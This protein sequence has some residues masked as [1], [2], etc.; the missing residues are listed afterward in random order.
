MDEKFLK[1]KKK[2]ASKKRGLWFGKKS[3][4]S[5]NP[6]VIPHLMRDPVTVDS[7][8]HGND[9]GG[10]FLNL[11]EKFFNILIW[12]YRLVC[13][14]A[15]WVD[16][17]KEKVR[18]FT[19]G[20][21]VATRVPLVM[22]KW[23][24]G[25]KQWVITRV[26]LVMKSRNVRI[27]ALSILGLLLAYG[28]VIHPLTVLL[29]INVVLL[30]T[31]NILLFISYKKDKCVPYLSP[32]LR[33]KYLAA[34]ETKSKLEKLYSERHQLK[35][36]F[37]EVGENAIYLR[38]WPYLKLVMIT[39]RLAVYKVYLKIIYHLALISS[40]SQESFNLPYASLRAQGGRGNLG[41]ASPAAR[42]DYILYHQKQKRISAFSLSGLVVMIIATSFS[43]MILSFVF[44]NIFKT[45]AATHTMLQT[46]WA[47]GA[48]TTATSTNTSDQT[49]WT[50]YNAA[51]ST[52]YFGTAGE[53]SLASSTSYVTSTDDS[54]TI[55]GF[56]LSGVA[57]SST[58]ITGTGDSASLVVSSTSA[59]TIYTTSTP[60]SSNWIVPDGVTSVKV[61]AWG[62]GGG[63]GGTNSAPSYQGGGGGGGAYARVDALVVTAGNSIPYT[64]GAKGT[65]GNQTTGG[66]GGS[67]SFNTN[68][69]I[70]Y[71]GGGGGNSLTGTGGA[72]GTIAGS[73][74]DVKF[75]GGGGHAGGACCNGYGGGGG[76]SGGSN[77]NG[78]WGGTGSLS[79]KEGNAVTDGGPGGTGAS[80]NGNG[81]APTS[82]PGGGGGGGKGNSVNGGN[83]E[84]GQLKLTYNAYNYSATGTYTS[85]AINI[86]SSTAWDTLQYATTTQA[87]TDVYFK[88]RSSATSDFSGA[89]AW[90]SCSFITNNSALSTGGC[91]TNSQQY[92]QYQ[93][94]LSSSSTSVTPS[95]NSVT[96]GYKSYPA[97]STLISSPFDSEQ[98]TN[99]VTNLTW[100]ETLPAGTDIKF[101]IRTSGDGVT[102]SDWLGPT[103]ASDYYSTSTAS[104]INSTQK[105]GAND[106]FVQYQV[107]LTSS[108][109]NTPT[110]SDVTLTYVVNDAPDFD[111][112]TSVTAS[113]QT[114]DGYV[115]I[116]YSV[117][118]DDTAS[119][120]V[121]CPLC[122]TPSFEYS[123][124]NGSTWTSILTG[125]STNATTTKTV[126]T[127]SYMAYS[128][129]WNA[130]GILN[131]TYASQAKIRITANDGEGANATSVT[132]TPAFALDV[133]APTPGAIPIMVMATSTPAALML[134]ATDDSSFQMCITLD[135]TATNCVPYNSTSTISLATDP[136]TV[137]VYFKD[138]YQNTSAGNSADTPSTPTL[139]LVKDVSNI[140][141]G[142]YREF[143]AWKKVAGSFLDYRVLRS[144]DNSNYT[145]I[146]K[147]LDVNTNYYVD[148]NLSASTTYYYKTA[149]EDANGNVSY[150]SSTLSDVVNGQG[151]TDTTPPT[152]SAVTVSTST[153]QSAII[154]WNTDEL[155][156][157]YIDYGLSA[158]SFSTTVGVTTMRD[159]AANAGQHSVGVTGLSP[160]TTYYYRVRS[161]DPSSNT[162]TD[163]NSGPGYSFTTPSGPVLSAVSANNVNN[164]HAQIV[165]T[166]DVASDSFVTYSTS[167]VF[168][169]SLSTGSDSDNTTSHSVT[170]TGL[171]K[172][173]AYYYY[174]NSGIGRND[175]GGSYY[176]F[177]TENDVTP[178][179]ISNPTASLIIDTKAVVEWTTDENADSLVEVG[180]S[181]G[182][183]DTASS[184]NAALGK[185][186]SLV[187]TG[188]SASQ[189]YKYI[190][191]SSD[192][193]GNQAT[194]TEQT[195]NTIGTLST[196]AQL[197]AAQA[198]ANAAGQLTGQNSVS[199]PAVQIC[200]VVDTTP[201][202]ITG[203]QV[204]VSNLNAGITWSTDEQ[205]DS[206]VEYSTNAGSLGQP[207]GNFS[208][209]YK[210]NIGLS[211]LD[212]GTKYYFMV[213]SAD[214]AG[215]RATSAVKN[216]TTLIAAGQSVILP[217]TPEAP[218]ST[219]PAQ[220]EK[221]P[222]KNTA[223]DQAAFSAIDT[224]KQ[225]QGQFSVSGLEEKSQSILKAFAEFI[226]AP[227]LSGEPKVLTTAHEATI[228][229]KTNKPASSL[230]ALAPE[231]EFNA[232][233]GDDAYLQVI[234]KPDD[235]VIDHLV[236]LRDL[237]PET[238]YHYQVRS[239]DGVG[240]MAKSGD[241]TFKT[242]Q[243]KLEI[244]DYV[245]QVVTPD[246]VIFKWI[247]TVPTDS[248]IKYSPYR[249]GVLAIDEQKT[250]NEKTITT[251]HELTLDNLEAGTNYQVELS[252]KDVTGQNISKVIPSF[253][254][255][256][257]NLPP[258][259]Y[260]VQTESALSPGGDSK[261]Q[262]II[263]WLT[264]EP[265]T[266]QV[267]YQK[268]VGTPDEKAWSQTILDP[269]YTKKH[270]V[271]I[272]KFEAGA[273]YKFKIQD[274]DSGNNLA[275]SRV[276]TI[277]SPSQKETVFQI[278]V[279][280][281][282]KTFGWTKKLGI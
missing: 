122:I 27:V 9:R 5:A 159:T 224:I 220:A 30:L 207:D 59:L 34:G 78:N 26:P 128:L 214:A 193:N 73:T 270:V 272:T 57:F 181:S 136:D 94:L 69:V 66:N 187:V 217:N 121:G 241:F 14:V 254:T 49:G 12:M 110:L 240:N 63:G 246:Q 89:T 75:S 184:T 151:G 171:T 98:T 271:V 80:S 105:D 227:I 154:V 158:G 64:V 56:N 25:M 244:S 215:N 114:S 54:T 170:I 236:I 109:V 104:S 32:W 23:F 92:I 225:L 256:K 231:K 169:Y 273:V 208:L 152:I 3:V 41:I 276:Y 239:V 204:G 120:G 126:G 191:V 264:N 180:T 202:T 130:K 1:S 147:I 16:E 22:T 131:G 235:L 149:T 166:T 62:G 87:S 7:H 71:F 167:S 226:P 197:A 15:A 172:G 74:G 258:I 234:G 200:P 218:T 145:V 228:V 194:S 48:S 185:A 51:S 269:N 205:A 2:R 118:D 28:L 19:R 252:G 150:F 178:P 67:T 91:V 55:T 36:K 164:T 177:N 216:F 242:E 45:F 29:T 125:L 153:P 238:T 21:L 90:S 173:T 137:Y 211:G 221:T 138:A 82:T 11:K 33:K 183:Y 108:G 139:L 6:S 72:S 249:N 265:S 116:S 163:D 129:T 255:S 260:Q 93:A 257:S 268:G 18:K 8:L 141:A 219:A 103:G 39:V 65:G 24:A 97:T 10:L 123:L 188:L 111:P 60:G 38:L 213:L 40:S 58:T 282:Q 127:S 266:G 253:S 212:A 47:G 278:I 168:A 100:T 165:W 20:T 267:F 161:I 251:L 37:L 229:W 117:R 146:T 84:A 4:I 275:E 195:L 133:K 233:R 174:V 203:I 76:S 237:Q 262:T 201:P 81:S 280:N 43:S 190:V 132:S 144:T 85:G 179:V 156:S 263:S 248:Q 106:R 140:G 107:W 196:A 232:I 44:P 61:E 148:G 86:A 96:I 112:N 95:L 142:E 113:Q 155:S 277:L 124:N 274:T 115:A 223:F 279:N 281:F 17:Q 261:V 189:A 182:I 119:S 175:N 245:V 99:V 192:T 259:I 186:H 135:N 162:A 198:A 222:E 42:N 247:T 35:I 102:W 206:F 79:Y 53:I 210:H 83:G 230:V 157:S 209:G 250:V 13:R 50:Q 88:A 143:V 46:S 52:I 77:A 101:Q 176:S 31:I 68:S 199:C 243:E 70:A 160:N 134:N